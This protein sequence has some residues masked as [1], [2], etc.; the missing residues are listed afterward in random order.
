VS[1]DLLGITHGKKPKFVKEY[2]A[3]GTQIE[4]AVKAYADD[5]RGRRF[6][7]A[8]YTY[9]NKPAVAP[10]P[11]QPQTPLNI[12]VA[13]TDVEPSREPAKQQTGFANSILRAIPRRN[14]N[15]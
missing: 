4:I 13:N 3:L 5:V 6:P 10:A 9:S 12:K 14:D 11:I 7:D 15:R 8:A 2:A 1:E